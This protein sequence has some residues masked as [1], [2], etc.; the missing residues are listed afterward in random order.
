MQITRGAILRPHSQSR[1]FSHVPKQFYRAYNPRDA[2]V[3]LHC[4]STPYPGARSGIDHAPPM[5]SHSKPPD[6]DAKVFRCALT[7]ADGQIPGECLGTPPLWIDTSPWDALCAV[8][9]NITPEPIPTMHKGSST[10]KTLHHNAT[11]SNT[12]LYMPVSIK[13][14]L[15]NVPL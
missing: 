6:S 9:H 5:R 8:A 3:S 4:E 14:H 12:T 15:Q 13:A 7:I 1:Q 2:S 10:Q 11:A